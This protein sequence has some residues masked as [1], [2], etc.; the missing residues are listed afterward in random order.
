MAYVDDEGLMRKIY[1]PKGTAS[2]AYRLYAEKRWDD[3]ARFPAYEK[4]GYDTWE[5]DGEKYSYLR[6]FVA[7]ERQ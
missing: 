3:L 1:T 2:T 6:E 7:D 5:A 4:Q